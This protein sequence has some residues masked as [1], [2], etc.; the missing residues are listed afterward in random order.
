M[1]RRFTLRRD[2]RVDLTLEG[3]EA[4]L[5]RGLPAEL[6]ALYE[7]DTPDPA[8]DR[9]FP[10]AYLDPTEEQAEQQWQELVYPELLQGRL[11]N[12]ERITAALDAADTGRKDRLV[13]HLNPDDVQAWLGV[14]NDARL[15]L[16]TRIGV[17]DETDLTELDPDDPATP[18]LA[19]YA[20]LTYLEG[21]LVEALLGG[22]PG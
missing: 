5:L 19:A 7:S 22:M 9:L 8:H 6:R 21:E 11:A 1:S 14:L 10:R 16:G 17:T 20:W 2:G 18:V 3:P 12:L 15:T 13:V 4:D